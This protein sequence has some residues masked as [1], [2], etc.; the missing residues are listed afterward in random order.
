M[1]AE[2][3]RRPMTGGLR[4]WQKR[5]LRLVHRVASPS[6]ED[7]LPAGGLL[8]NA[9]HDDVVDAFVTVTALR[10]LPAIILTSDDGDSQ[11]IILAPAAAGG[12][13]TATSWRP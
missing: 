8:A 5:I 1:M 9:G 11:R 12:P 7:A 2:V 3:M 13:L 4:D 6:I 10:A